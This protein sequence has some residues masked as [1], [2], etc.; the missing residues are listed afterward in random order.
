MTN[1]I[2]T[3]PALKL[4]EELLV[5]SPSC[6]E[7]K[8]SNVIGDILNNYGYA[9]TIDPAGNVITKLPGQVPE[10]PLI[11]FAAHMDEIGM[12]ISSIE[13]N[14]DLR[15]TR[16]GGL[17]PWKLGEGPLDI[18]GD[19]RT[20]QGILSMGSTHTPKATELTVTWEDV[21]VITG[22]TPNQLKVAGVR[23]GTALLPTL[24]RRGPVTFGNKDDPLV[25]AWTF[26]DRMGCVTL[27]RLMKKLKNN[28]IAPK[29]TSII[30]FTTREEIGGHGA[31]YLTRSTN[32]DVFISVDGCPIPPGSPLKIDG[33][34]G[35]WS[36]DRIALYDQEMLCLFS[37]AAL[38][39]GTELQSAVFDGAAS[40]A[41]L[42]SYA[43][44]VPKIVCI[45]HV[46]EN[47]HGFEVAR[48]SVF[49]NLLNT[50]FEFIKTF[51]DQ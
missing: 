5:P 35:I 22:L 40:D 50:L 11:V 16:S 51:G 1:T 7:K 24:D 13:S 36:K 17:H 41:S 32:P 23:P 47:S 49:D 6:S 25:S 26:D 30:A 39:A 3:H 20:I 21:R 2:N 34:P 19:H 14:G 37:Q 42:V 46:R 33:R 18:F 12:V 4:F 38:R 27:L 31:K 15:V 10:A 8:I 29:Y 45:G 43:L 44:G 28:E 48:L 9:H